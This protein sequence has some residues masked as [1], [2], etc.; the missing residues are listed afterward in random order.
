MSFAKFVGQVD[1][2]SMFADGEM[3]AVQ[4]ILVGAAAFV[5]AYSMIRSVLGR[6]GLALIGVVAPAAALTDRASEF[7]GWFAKTPYQAA[8]WTMQA[9]TGQGDGQFYRDGPFLMTAVGWWTFFCLVL[10]F[11]DG[12]LLL[13]TQKAAEADAAPNGGPETPSG[14]SRVPEGPPSVS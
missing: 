5:G 14:S 1:W 11:R 7:L 8:L 3:L 10:V 9:L 13:R 4:L 12:L 6:F 2:R